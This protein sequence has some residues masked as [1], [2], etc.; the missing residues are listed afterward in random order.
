MAYQER[1]HAKKIGNPT[2]R[3]PIEHTAQR[4][5]EVARKLEAAR[6]KRV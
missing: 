5:A 4:F 6:T 1:K 3:A 2:M